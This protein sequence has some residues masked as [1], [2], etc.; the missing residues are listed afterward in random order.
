MSVVPGLQIRHLPGG[1]C[2]SCRKPG[3]VR[4]AP[5]SHARPAAIPFGDRL[6]RQCQQ[7][8]TR[9][10]GE[11]FT[12]N[13]VIRGAT[14]TKNRRRPSQADHRESG[15]RV[16]HFD[17]AGGR[18]ASARSPPHASHA[19]STR[20]GRSRLPPARR[21]YAIDSC[22]PIGTSGE[23]PAGGWNVA[24]RP[25]AERIASRLEAGRNRVPQGGF[26]LAPQRFPTIVPT[27]P[28]RPPCV[29]PRRRLQ[30]C[31]V[32][33][34]LLSSA[35]RNRPGPMP[36]TRSAGGELRAVGRGHKSFV[37]TPTRGRQRPFR[38]PRTVGLGKIENSQQVSTTIPAS[39]AG[40]QMK[41]LRNKEC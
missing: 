32:Q 13:L 29:H 6:H 3:P 17:G 36:L 10:N 35:S 22:S 2:R 8:V 25:E 18:E 16:D 26:H 38:A 31:P 4:H 14:A 37:P 12:E 27:R 7:S 5:P 24:F 39:R 21:L 15:V 41:P 28:S 19:I 33:D 40:S 23:G 20:I 34:P 9:K 11:R 30:H 1:P